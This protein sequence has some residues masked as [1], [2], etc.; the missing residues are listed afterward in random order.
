MAPTPSD[1]TPPP[2]GDRT[3]SAPRAGTDRRF[4]TR[5]LLAVLALAVAAVPCG[6]LLVLVEGHWGPLW[7][8]DRG[9]ADALH[10]AVRAHPALLDVL[11]VCTDLLWGPWTMR[12]MITLLCCWLAARRAWRLALWAALTAAAS[13]LIG[14]LVKKVVARTR[15]ALPDPVAHAGGFSFPSGHAMTAMTCCAVAL[16][17][18]LPVVPRSWR[19]VAWFAALVPV[20][21]V[22]FTRVALGVHWVSDVLGGWLLGLALV[23]ATAWAFEAWRAETGRPVPAVTEGLEPELAAPGPSEPPRV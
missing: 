11:R 5:L 18:L 20:V 17:V 6:V 12:L 3:S 13:G 2:P 10:R 8:L 7:R 14:L 4:G 22:G 9:T 16:L 23:V 1:H 21:G 19:P 15:P